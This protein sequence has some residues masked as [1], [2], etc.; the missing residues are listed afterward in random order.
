MLRNIYQEI[1]SSIFIVFF[2]DS[3]SLTTVYFIC[4]NKVLDVSKQYQNV[5]A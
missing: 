1:E 4:C 3:F 2:V 5:I